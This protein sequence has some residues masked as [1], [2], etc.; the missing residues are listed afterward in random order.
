MPPG[1]SSTSQPHLH[2]TAQ[3]NF[4]DARGKMVALLGV[5]DLIV[6]DTPDA[7]LVATRDRAQQSGRYR[8]S[9]RKTREAR[10]AVGASRDEEATRRRGENPIAFSAFWSGSPLLRVGRNPRDP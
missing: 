7:L 2:R 5:K 1:M 6:V 4:V 9:A 8:Q 10:A 3:D